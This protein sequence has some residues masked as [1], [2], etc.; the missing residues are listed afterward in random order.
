MKQLLLWRTGELARVLLLIKSTQ[1]KRGRVSPRTSYKL[2][3]PVVQVVS[4]LIPTFKHSNIQT[5]IMQ[6]GQPLSGSPPLLLSPVA[7]IAS[8]LVAVSCV[9]HS[10]SGALLAGG[11]N[12]LDNIA[13]RRAK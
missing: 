8:N 5:F 13:K 3:L 7:S 11:F 12:L 4:N 9:W 1:K 10:I 6:W 2:F